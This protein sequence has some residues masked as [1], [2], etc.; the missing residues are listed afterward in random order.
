MLRGDAGTEMRHGFPGDSSSRW[1]V[2]DFAVSRAKS[3]DRNYTTVLAFKKRHG[4]TLGAAAAL[5]GGQSAGSKNKVRDIKN[6]TFKIGDMEH[7][8]AVAG[9][10]DLCRDCN[11]SFA[12]HA[13]FV[14]SISTALRIPEFDI[15][16]F[17]DRIRK[18]AANLRKRS[19]CLEYL[20]EI[21]AL[22]NYG[23]R[24]TRMPVKF[25][26]L[27][28]ARNRQRSFGRRGKKGE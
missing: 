3:G 25:R 24:K 9:I 12:T 28:I 6:G 21:D 7:G 23:A 8:N 10:T 18:Y 27:E 26:A 15:D 17:C 14:E 1:S 5:V 16:M 11:I 13:S 22:Y 2:T 4:L 19:N 20:D